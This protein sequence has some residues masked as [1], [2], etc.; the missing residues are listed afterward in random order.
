M[1]GILIAGLAGAGVSYLVLNGA[2]YLRKAGPS[3]KPPAGDFVAKYAPYLVGA[4]AVIALH[5][6]APQTV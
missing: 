2:D 4:A 1:K 6:F 5:K 3:G